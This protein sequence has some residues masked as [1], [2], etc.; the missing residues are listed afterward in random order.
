[1]SMRQLE[2][3]SQT[4]LMMTTF[5]YGFGSHGFIVTPLVKIGNY[6]SWF[7]MIIANLLAMLFIW[8][9]AS[10]TRKLP[11]QNLLEDGKLIVGKWVH[12]G[13]LLYM[14]YFFFHLGAF[15]LRHFVDFLIQTYFPTTPEEVLLFFFIFVVVV[16]VRYGFESIARFA[17]LIFFLGVVMSLTIPVFLFKDIDFDMAIAFINRFEPL[18]IWE[19]VMYVIPWYA[20]AIVFV[21]IMQM[22]SE[23]AKTTKSIFIGSA[24]TTLIFFPFIITQVLMFGPHFTADMTIAGV[25]L[26]RQISFANFI[27]NIDPVYISLWLTAIFVKISVCLLVS[28]T[29]AAK[30]LQVKDYRRLLNALGLCFFGFS[31]HMSENYSETFEFLLEGWVGFAWTVILLPVLYWLVAKIR[32][33]GGEKAKKSTGV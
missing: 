9:G 4:Q 29:L 26:L 6:S 7:I 3:I 12:Y 31:I 20:D 33:I 5:M 1:M 13:V 14:L 8:A 21:L 24:F 11:S 19:G 32:R 30:L 2:Q 16:A 28:S 23:K 10:V 17:Q 22:I 27:E 25:E 18:I 15:I